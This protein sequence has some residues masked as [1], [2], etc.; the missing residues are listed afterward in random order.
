M[1]AG[2]FD[3]LTGV[4]DDGRR[5]ETVAEDDHLILSITSNLNRLFNTRR[6]AIEHMPDY[7]LPDISEVYRDMPDSAVL[8]QNAIREAVEKYEP[9]L[10]RVRIEH[11][12]TDRYAMRL[13]FILTGEL[14]NRQRVKLQTTFSSNE[15]AAVHH[16]QRFNQDGR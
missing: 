13:E 12:Q 8:L 9:R 4:F 7:G 2:L 6:G 11:T 14:M 3:T 1:R 16:L 5:L 15:L 10:R